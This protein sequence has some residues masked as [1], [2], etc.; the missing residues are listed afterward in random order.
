MAE[1]YLVVSGI[2]GAFKKIFGESWGPRLENILRHAIAVLVTV[3]DATIGDLPRLLTDDKFR[4]RALWYVEDGNIKQ[5]FTRQFNHYVARFRQEA[6]DPVLNKV[7]HFLSNPLLNRVLTHTENHIQM[8]EIMDGGK[9]LIANLSRGAIG[10]DSS[11]LLGALLL[12]HIE[13][14][15]LSRTDVPASLRVLH[16]VFVDEFATMATPSFSGMLAESRKFGVYLVVG[17]QT[18]SILDDDIRASLFGNIGS[19]I[20]FQTSAEDAQYLEHEFSPIFT[21]D[22]FISLPRY[23]IYLKLMIEGEASRPFS[24]VTLPPI[25]E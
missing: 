1:P 15:T 24:A 19:H 11:A 8:R 6:V 13:R 9:I 20:C 10:E 12:A 21:A 4:E 17:T 25:S 2:V 14:A 3:P 18:I 22:D 23:H 5:F 16:G 7:G